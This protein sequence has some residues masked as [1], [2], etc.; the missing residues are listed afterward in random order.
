[1]TE[2]PVDPGALN[3]AIT[4][5]LDTFGD[6]HT[7]SSGTRLSDAQ[8]IRNLVEEGVLAE[9]TGVDYFGIGEHHTQS[10]PLSA[11]DVVLAAIAA[12]TSRIHLG[13][14]VTVIS[15]DDPVRVFQRYSTLDSLS[16]GRAEVILGRG[17]STESFPLFGYDLRDYDEL[18]EEKVN[19]FAELLKEKPV[20]WSGN[21]RAALHGQTV[22]PRTQSGHLSTWIGVGGSPESVVRA[23]RY[24]FALMIAIIGGE[25]ARFA[26]FA[27]LFHRA[28]AEFGQPGL[29]VGV[30]SPG[31]VAATDERAIEEFWPH[32]ETAFAEAARVRGFRPPTK[33]NFLR[34]VGPGG[35]TVCGLARDRGP[36]DHRDAQDTRGE[37]L[38]PEVRH[39]RGAPEPNNEEHRALRLPRGSNSARHGGVDAMAADRCIRSAFGAGVMD[40]TSPA[41]RRPLSRAG[42]L[43][44]SNHGT[45]CQGSLQPR[46]EVLPNGMRCSTG[47]CPDSGRTCDGPDCRSWL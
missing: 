4:L 2:H 25:T 46:P 47:R 41:K 16:N 5:G 17:S 21:T 3:P 34:D 13:S 20:T 27:G 37:P 42:G 44:Y 36:K 30:H 24:G 7:D 33:Q 6:V 31:H 32:Y 45:P 8:T 23:A 14:A 18:F 19:L 35:C 22:Y 28:L 26:P 11:G 40:S 15:S 43:E 9:E 38:R 10:F 12:R 29:P 39:A 1:M